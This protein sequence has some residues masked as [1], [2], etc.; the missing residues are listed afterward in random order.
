MGYTM[1]KTMILIVSITPIWFGMLFDSGQKSINKPKIELINGLEC[2]HN[3]D[4]PLFPER[5]IIFKEELSIGAEDK[6]GNIVFIDPW[7]SLVDDEENIY[8]IEKKDKF[9]RVFNSDGKQIKTIGAKGSGPGEFQAISPF[10]AVTK[11]GKT[12][13]PDPT[14]RRTSIFDSS[15]RFINSFR[16]R[17]SNS[18]IILIKEASFIASAMSNSWNALG[19]YVAIIVNEVDFDGNER[20]IEGEFSV[21]R[22]SPINVGGRKVFY[23]E[24]V[25]TMSILVGD[26]DR[27]RFYHC[28]NNKY[29]IEVYDGSGKLFRKIDRPYK[30][31]RFNAADVS[32]YRASLMGL[33]KETIEAIMDGEMP[34]EKSIVENMFVDGSGNLWIQTNEHKKAENKTLTAF[35]IFDSDGRF[36]CKVW[37]SI[38]PKI[39]KKSKMYLLE[40]DNHTGYPVLKR[41]KMMWK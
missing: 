18:N 11:D 24:P 21:T 25:V 27:Q 31:V 19:Q 33:N 6:D 10:I 3:S 16:W 40:T 1:R 28:I 38:I 17:T 23:N 2:I 41:Y 13:A 35:D 34:K 4:S 29:L 14:S 30:P 12:I 39:F 32:D 9:I 36:T 15:G 22:F 20:E 5:T 37:S 26:Q 7:L 8:L